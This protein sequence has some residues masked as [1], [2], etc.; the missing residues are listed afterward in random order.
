MIVTEREQKVTKIN[1]SKNK[2]NE[3]NNKLKRVAMI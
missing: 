1:N 3:Q 2:D